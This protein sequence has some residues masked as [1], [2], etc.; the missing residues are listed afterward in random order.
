MCCQI[1]ALL[2]YNHVKFLFCL[3]DSKPE[4]EGEIFSASKNERE[5]QLIGIQVENCTYTK[6]TINPLPN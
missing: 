4:L 2:M 6:V 5:P 1:S 3:L